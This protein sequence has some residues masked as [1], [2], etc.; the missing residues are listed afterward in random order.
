MPAEPQNPRLLRRALQSLAA[1]FLGLALT[2]AGPAVA[3]ED[4]P[5]SSAQTS[6][7]K[8]AKPKFIDD[9]GETPKQRDKRLRRECKGRPNAGA[10]AGYT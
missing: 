3:A 9:T 1:S 4:K 2:L 8:V 6:K 7:E 10:C 5:K